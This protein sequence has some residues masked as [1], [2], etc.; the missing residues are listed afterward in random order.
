MDERGDDSELVDGQQ[1]VATM[2]LL[3]L[4]LR[5]LLKSRSLSVFNPERRLKCAT[6]SALRLVLQDAIAASPSRPFAGA[7]VLLA[8]RFQLL[9]P[10]LPLL[11]FFPFSSDSIASLWLCCH[12]RPCHTSAGYGSSSGQETTSRTPHRHTA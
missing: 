10:L 11:L 9:T 5:D 6:D 1:R 3:I 4:A 7:L 2:F 12:N 8:P